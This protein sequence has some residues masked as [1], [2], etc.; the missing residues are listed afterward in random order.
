MAQPIPP[1]SMIGLVRAR[2]WKRTLATT[3]SLASLR[4]VALGLRVVAAGP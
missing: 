1:D 4:E 2:G 3:V